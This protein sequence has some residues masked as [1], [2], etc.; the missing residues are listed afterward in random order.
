[1]RESHRLNRPGDRPHAVH[2]LQIVSL[3]TGGGHGCSLA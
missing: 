2:L 3:C 1:L